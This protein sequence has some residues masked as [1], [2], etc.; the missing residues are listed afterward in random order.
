MGF[1]QEFEWKLLHLFLGFFGNFP[2]NASR[3]P[4]RNPFRTLFLRK[5]FELFL[6][7]FSLQ[8]SS[9]ETIRIS[10]RQ[11]IHNFFPDSFSNISSDSW[12]NFEFFAGKTFRRFLIK[13]FF[14][15]FYWNLQKLLQGF[16]RFFGDI[17]Y[18]F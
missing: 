17:I 16:Q 6:G 2:R 11:L 14:S 5:F 3:Q 12:W 4:F 18:D 1:N 15:E 9:V 13:E 8:K 10:Y 7:E